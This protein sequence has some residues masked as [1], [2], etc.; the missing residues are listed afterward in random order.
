MAEQHHVRGRIRCSLA[1]IHPH[2][3]RR[4][5]SADAAIICHRCG[6][7]LPIKSQQQ[8]RDAFHP[9]TWELQHWKT[10]FCG[11]CTLI[12]AVRRVHTAPRSYCVACLAAADEGVPILDIP[13]RHDYAVQL[14]A[15]CITLDMDQLLALTTKEAVK[16]AAQRA[17]ASL[18]DDDTVPIDG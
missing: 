14:C 17:F 18:R 13:T 8:L 10:L 4:D 9:S 16:A 3:R 2:Y 12:A 6:A 11:S 7:D 5:A 1:D 15:K